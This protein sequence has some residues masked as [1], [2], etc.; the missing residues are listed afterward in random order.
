MSEK[1]TKDSETITKEI[2]CEHDWTLTHFLVADIGI[3]GKTSRTCKK[4]GFHQN[5]VLVWDK[6]KKM[7]FKSCGCRFDDDC[8]CEEDEDDE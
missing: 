2:E 4:C 6:K 8:D 5:G 3:D 7:E 1:E